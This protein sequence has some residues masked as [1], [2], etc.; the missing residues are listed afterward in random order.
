VHIRRHRYSRNAG[1]ERAAPPGTQRGRKE[2]VPTG[3]Y[4]VAP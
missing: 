2:A 4:T 3:R 1:D